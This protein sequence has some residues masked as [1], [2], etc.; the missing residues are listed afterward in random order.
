MA[1]SEQGVRNST[2]KGSL[3]PVRIDWIAFVEG[4]IPVL[5]GIYATA[6]GFGWIKGR[7]QPDSASQKWIRHFR[8]LGPLLI[9][10]GLLLGWQAYERGAHP[11]AERLAAGIA[12]RLQLP[13]TV[14]ETTR[15]DAVAG[16]GETITYRYTVTVPIDPGQVAI[17]EER[18]REQARAV[19]CTHP[20]FAELLR[21]GYTVEMKY[22]LT[23]PPQEFAIVTA[24]SACPP[25]A[26]G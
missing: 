22:S 6:L 26:D 18:L 5:A 9:A 1:G 4:G 8:W 3:S 7:A 17:F 13:V 20:G 10:I 12:S 15:L 24:P 21:A 23:E 25:P 11:S 2:A 16:S 14:D 19:A